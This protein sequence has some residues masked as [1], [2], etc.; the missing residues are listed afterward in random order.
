M[1][2]LDDI[3]NDKA[4]LIAFAMV[5]RDRAADLGL[6][7]EDLNKLALEHPSEVNER[8]AEL[9]KILGEI[10]IPSLPDHV[11]QEV[12]GPTEQDGWRL[13]EQVLRFRLKHPDAMVCFYNGQVSYSDGFIHFILE[14]L[15]AWR[16]SQD[17]FCEQVEVPYETLCSWIEKF[18]WS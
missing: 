9:E 1:S 16:Y 3:N 12:S 2:L 17:R 10:E 14:R 13:R 11:D 7:T 15:D 18:N 4:K 6:S 8:Q 5:M